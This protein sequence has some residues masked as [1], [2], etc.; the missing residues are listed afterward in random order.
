MGYQTI[1][2]DMDGTLLDTLGDLHASVNAVLRAQGFPER[3]IGEVRSFVGN[4]AERLIRCAVP[5]GTDEA[6]IA[7]T[8]RLYQDYYAAHC[9]ILTRAYDGI[10]PLLETLRAAGKHLAVV[11]N[12]PDRATKALAKLYFGEGLLAVGEHEGVRRKPWRDMVDAAIGTLGA[13]RESAVYV[14][15]SEVDVQTARNAELPLIAVSWG[16]RGREALRAADAET[17]VD[18]AE[19]LLALTL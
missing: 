19:E 7:A 18:T 12:K 11:S 3:S 16:F 4:G 10:L 15:D 17:I 1:L 6:D 9:Q 14:G 2:F 13:S 5:E 8:L